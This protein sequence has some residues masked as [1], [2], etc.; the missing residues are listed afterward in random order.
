M[1]QIALG[2]KRLSIPHDHYI[3]VRAKLTKI[4]SI[5]FVLTVIFPWSLNSFQRRYRTLMC[6]S[7]LEVFLIQFFL[8]LLGDVFISVCVV[9]LI[10]STFIRPV[11]KWQ[12]SFKQNNKNKT[13][14]I[15]WKFPGKYHQAFQYLFYIVALRMTF[16]HQSPGGGGV[17]HYG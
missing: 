2:S 12:V 5:F 4:S 8:W 17:P 15:M 9:G 11:I 3:Y 13:Y 7:T 1:L 6:L 10:W 14:R 16:D